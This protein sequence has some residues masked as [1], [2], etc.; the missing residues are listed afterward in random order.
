MFKYT[1]ETEMKLKLNLKVNTM[2]VLSI[3]GQWESGEETSG[4]Y[5]SFL[6]HWGLIYNSK[7]FH[8]LSILIYIFLFKIHTAVREITHLTWYPTAQF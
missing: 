3:R 7:W 5:G 6:W 8:F 4:T 2:R 1:L